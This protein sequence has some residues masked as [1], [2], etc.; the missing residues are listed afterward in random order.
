MEMLTKRRSTS[1]SPSTAQ[2]PGAPDA[3][4]RASWNRR[5]VQGHGNYI[6]RWRFTMPD[7]GQRMDLHLPTNEEVEAALR[8][9]VPITSGILRVE[10]E[11]D[12]AK[13]KFVRRG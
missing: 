2:L 13:A 1:S 5:V 12:A 10:I 9:L 8:V 11:W 3:A 4:H 7:I 6:A